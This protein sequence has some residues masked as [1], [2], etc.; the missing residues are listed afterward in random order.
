M[1]I[2]GDRRR[3]PVLVVVVIYED[4]SNL[5]LSVVNHRAART[6][7]GEGNGREADK[8]RRR[9]S[10]ENRPVPSSRVKRKKEESC[11]IKDITGT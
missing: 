5:V 2:A 6:T 10:H 9:Y 7:A 8:A 3:P 11:T 4:K 1:A